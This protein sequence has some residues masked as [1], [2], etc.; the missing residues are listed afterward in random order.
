MREDGYRFF[1]AAL[2]RAFLHADCLRLDHVMGLQRLYMIPDGHNATDGAYV[3]YKADELHAL[4]ALEASRAGTVVIGEDLG[5]VPK[6]VRQRMERDRML[7]M[8]VFQFESTPAQPLPAPSA[9]TLAS[10][11]THD[12]PR[13]GGFLWGEDIDERE[14]VGA[15]RPHEAAAAH[16]TRTRWRLKLFDALE[17]SPEDERE[18][19]TAEALRG[20]L[21]HMARSD[22]QIVL[23][24][25]E[26]M[27]DERL[28]QNH[29]G[30]ESNDNWRRRARRTFEDFSSD[31]ELTKTLSDLT[32]ERAS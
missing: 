9:D 11:G 16:T 5:T 22:A 1:S 30:T 21:R 24:D 23:V 27:W 26:E 32:A 18:T 8:W 25:L 31:P 14:G 12:L 10:L 3:S 13:F 29:P 17:L 2:R 28:A 19:V 15:L 20:C 7:R 6:G 4:V